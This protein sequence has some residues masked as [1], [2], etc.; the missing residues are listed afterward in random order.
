MAATQAFWEKGL[1]KNLYNMA[2]HHKKL[3]Y[4]FY[5]SGAGHHAKMY[6]FNIYKL[7]K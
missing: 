6:I 1:M 7:C 5:V 3:E 2:H 4:N